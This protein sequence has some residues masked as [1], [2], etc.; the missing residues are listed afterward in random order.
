LGEQLLATGTGCGGANRRRPS[1][2]LRD[3]TRRRAQRGAHR[4]ARGPQ[5]T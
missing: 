4:E 5:V 3:E 1:A 2:R